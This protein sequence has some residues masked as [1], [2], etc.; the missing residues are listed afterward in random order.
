MSSCTECHGNEGQHTF[1][2]CPRIT[3]A[4][5]YTPQQIQTLIKDRERAARKDELE[6]FQQQTRF[7]AQYLVRYKEY[8]LKA[9]SAPQVKEEE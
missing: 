8:R 1:G 4:K 7:H 3:G 6:Q 5:L 9:L 2:N